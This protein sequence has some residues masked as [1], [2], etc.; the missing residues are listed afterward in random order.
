MKARGTAIKVAM[1]VTKKAK[2]VVF[3]R[4]DAVRFERRSGSASKPT[5]T[6]RIER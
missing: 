5:P 6:V 4:P 1:D 2:T 3:R